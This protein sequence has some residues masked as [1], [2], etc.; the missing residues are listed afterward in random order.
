MSNSQRYVIS[1]FQSY[2]S[3]HVSFDIISREKILSERINT[4]TYKPEHVIFVVFSLERNQ[5]SLPKMEMKKNKKY[6]KSCSR[7]LFRLHILVKRTNNGQNNISKTTNNRHRDKEKIVAKI[8]T[9]HTLTQKQNI[10][11]EREEREKIHC[12]Y[13]GLY[14]QFCLRWLCC[15]RQAHTHTHIM[16]AF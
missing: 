3:Q 15:F 5:C 12:C 16:P 6:M 13:F 11:R 8:I 2:S 10:G 4:Y 7:L 14:L 1:V 9:T